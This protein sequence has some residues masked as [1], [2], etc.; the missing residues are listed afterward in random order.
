MIKLEVMLEK[1]R[2]NDE[3]VELFES[4]QNDARGLSKLIDTLLFLSRTEK[5]THSLHLES[6]S[7]KGKLESLVEFYE[8]LASEK[9]MV[10][11]LHM[12]SNIQISVEKIFLIELLEI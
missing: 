6:I 3:Y 1:P 4:L 7:L 2:T 12:D 10:I 9:N 8:P 5:P 11:E